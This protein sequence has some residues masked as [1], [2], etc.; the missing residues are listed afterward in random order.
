MNNDVYLILGLK[1]VLFIRP[2]CPKTDTF[3]ANNTKQISNN[4]LL[5]FFGIGFADI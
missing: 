1:S 2:Q 4:Q 5:I 3:L